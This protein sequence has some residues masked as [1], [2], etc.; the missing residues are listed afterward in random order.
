MSKVRVPQI[1]F[2]H[3]RRT[4][5]VGSSLLA[6]AL[7]LNILLPLVAGWTLSHAPSLCLPVPPLVVLGYYAQ[8]HMRKRRLG[9]RVFDGDRLKGLPCEHCLYDCT[10]SV[11]GQCPECAWV[12]APDLAQKWEN[13]RR[14]FWW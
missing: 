3:E 4:K 7:L 5:I 13:W 1:A 6:L 12:I 10:G 8:R 11:S 14:T 9:R 2:S